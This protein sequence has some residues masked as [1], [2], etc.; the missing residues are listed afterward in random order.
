M[1]LS[2]KHAVEST[3]IGRYTDTG[4]L[5]ITYNGKTCAYID[6]DLASKGFPQWEFEAEW[7]PPEARGLTEPVISEPTDYNALLLD[8]LERPNICSKEWITRQYDHEVQG[9]SVI[10]PLVGEER[11]VNSDASVLRPDTLIR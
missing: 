7:L 3:V 4:K 1:E 8:M 5:H 2:E 6:I 11:D 9:G 10:K